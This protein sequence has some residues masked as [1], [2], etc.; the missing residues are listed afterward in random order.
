[1]SK[2]SKE[3]PSVY[4][5]DTL[6]AW[7]AAVIERKK[8][9]QKSF[10]IRQL[11]RQLKIKA[12]S[13]LTMVMRGERQPS[14]ELAHKVATWLRL[15]KAEADFLEALVALQRAS[16]VEEQSR[17][18]ATIRKLRP[19]THINYRMDAIEMMTRWY[20]IVILEMTRLA[21]F[22]DNVKKI[23]TQ[24]GTV[25]TE[26]MVEAALKALKK[27]KLVKADRNGVIRKAA[28]VLRSTV[29]IPSLAIRSF[30]K[31]VLL[32]AHTAI[33]QQAIDERY[34][35][36]LTIAIPRS[37]IKI[38]GELISRFRDQFMAEM[39]GDEQTP[40]EI[41]HLAVQFFRATENSIS[42]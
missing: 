24:L 23:K 6:P 37:K 11:A 29:N 38:A 10:S 33:D 21:D 27:H 28:D 22:Q 1:M 42:R 14:P 31:Q 30:H 3:L 39:T 25:V 32:R 17:I 20:A 40:E 9:Q 5:Y 2:Q 12:P 18:A 4:E 16:N 36:S 34:F 7:L 35:T 8:N 15:P 26:D 13:A 41:Y 19:S